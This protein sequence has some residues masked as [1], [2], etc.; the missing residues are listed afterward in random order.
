ME[1]ERDSISFWFIEVN[2][3]KGKTKEESNISMSNCSQ[4]E[5]QSQRLLEGLRFDIPGCTIVLVL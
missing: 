2:E 1:M 5:I 4:S 3:S